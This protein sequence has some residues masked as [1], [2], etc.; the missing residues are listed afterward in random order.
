MPRE[1]GTGPDGRGRQSGRGEGPCG[2]TGQR[3][4]Q[5]KRRGKQGK[6]RGGGREQGQG[7]GSGRGRVQK[8]T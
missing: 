8:L 7:G 4:G 2:K 6:G 5:G 1:D 3:R